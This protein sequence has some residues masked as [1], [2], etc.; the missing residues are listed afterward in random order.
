MAHGQDAITEFIYYWFQQPIIERTG[1]NPVNTI[2]YAAIALIAVYIIWLIFQ[3]RKLQID[4]RFIYAILA[5]VLFGSTVRIITDISEKPIWDS[6]PDV[7]PLHNPVYNLGWYDYD[8]YIIPSPGIYIVTAIL[9]LIS[10]AVLWALKKQQYLMHVG[11]ALW[12]PHFLVILP[13]L[14]N[15]ALHAI[16]ILILTALPAYFVHKKYSN[17]TLTLVQ[18]SHGLDGAATFYAIDIFPKFSNV[19]Y[20]EQHVLGGFIGEFFGTYFAFYALK[21]LLA[22]FIVDTLH[23]EKASANYKNYIALVI[24]IIGFAPGLRDVLRMMAGV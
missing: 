17:N 14:G 12:L 2:V 24:I 8:A 18:A 10:L 6:F 23:K 4:Q 22:Y 20:G 19:V 7:S 5:F 1:Y 11:L 9:F 13:F 15:Y 21:I 3:R 16:P